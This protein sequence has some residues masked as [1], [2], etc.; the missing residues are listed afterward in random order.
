MSSS[1][2]P[3]NRSPISLICQVEIAEMGSDQKKTMTDKE[4]DRS[5]EP[6][7]ATRK[8]TMVPIEPLFI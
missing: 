3:Q 2:P 1:T 5:D 4:T 6:A 8:Y 7:M